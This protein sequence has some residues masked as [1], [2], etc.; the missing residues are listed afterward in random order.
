MNVSQYVNAFLKKN[1]T[2]FIFEMSGGMITHILDS[3]YQKNEI[4]IN[5]Q[6]QK[7]KNDTLKK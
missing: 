4:K 5:I 1:D 3:V 6:A 2:K 7:I